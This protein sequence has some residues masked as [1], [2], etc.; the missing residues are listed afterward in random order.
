MSKTSTKINSVHLTVQ[1][2]KHKDG[3]IAYAPSLDLSTVGK[4]L[5]KSQRMISEAIHIF[6]DELITRGTLTK[7]LSGLGWVQRRSAWSPPRM[8]KEKSISLKLPA[9][10]TA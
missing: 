3:V 8:I 7:V 5:A 9:L 1:F 10:V 2:I 4:T 6:F